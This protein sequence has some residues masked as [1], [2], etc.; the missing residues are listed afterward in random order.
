[1]KRNAL[2]LRKEA[3]WDR[4]Y[5][6]AKVCIHD[7]DEC[8]GAEIQAVDVCGPTTRATSIH[9]TIYLISP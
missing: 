2:V 9:V 6:M 3:G 8:S 1:M 5:V 7:D 4:T